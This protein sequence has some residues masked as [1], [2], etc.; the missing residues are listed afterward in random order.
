MASALL[1]GFLLGFTIAASPGPIALLCVRR[2]LA[3]GW[4]EGF[5][6]GLGAATAD[7][8]YGGIAA[9][10]MSAAAHLLLSERRWLALAGGLVLI[11]LGVRGL[12]DRTE[13]DSG[14][15]ST[16]GSLARA[17]GSVVGLTLANPQTI[18]GFAAAFGTAGILVRLVPAGLTLGVLAGSAAWWALLAGGVAL[19][20]RRLG[21]GPVRLLRAASGGLLAALGAAAVVAAVL[22]R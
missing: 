6:S 14:G 12:V 7:G 21:T 2:T 20:R 11:A 19:A 22:A 15:E 1:A 18:I 3:R 8:F 5:A 10:G 9:F 4:P 13:P 17:Y 16:P